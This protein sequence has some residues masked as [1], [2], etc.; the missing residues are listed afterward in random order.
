MHASKVLL[1]QATVRHVLYRT[2]AV[3]VSSKLPKLKPE[4]VTDAPAETA[5]FG[6]STPVSVGAS[7]EAQETRRVPTTALTVS[8]IEIGTAETGREPGMLK[9]AT[10]VAV[11][12]EADAQ[13]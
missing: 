11:T 4:M 10:V 2:A 12:H 9:Q 1:V 8:C 5:R 7:K 3:G 13:G 6:R